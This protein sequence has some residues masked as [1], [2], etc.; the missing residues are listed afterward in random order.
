MSNR[1]DVVRAYM[2]AYAAGDH[3]GVAALL[4]DDVVWIVF[5]HG[6]FEGREAFLEEMRSGEAPGLPTIRVDRYIEQG[7]LV[8]ATGEVSALLPDGA[9]LHLGFSDVFTFRGDLISQLDAY[10]VSQAAPTA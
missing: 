7:D 3:D 10:L 2:T 6:R 8:C 5:G 4:A 1:T 9:A